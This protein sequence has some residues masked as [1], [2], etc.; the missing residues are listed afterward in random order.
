MKIF[1]A[2]PLCFTDFTRG[3]DYTL[4]IE[5]KFLAEDKKNFFF[6]SHTHLVDALHPCHSERILEFFHYGLGLDSAIAPSI[7]P[8]S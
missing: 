5:K 1:E 7:V 2:F 8:R 3:T 6:N 4:R